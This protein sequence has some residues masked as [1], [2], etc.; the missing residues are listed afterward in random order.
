MEV[1]PPG[2]LAPS[3]GYSLYWDS[4]SFQFVYC[5]LYTLRTLTQEL[6]EETILA[7]VNPDNVKERKK[8]RKLSLELE[9]LKGKISAISDAE[10]F[11][12]SNREVRLLR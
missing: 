1:G 3:S 10:T 6:V 9:S 8:Q 7:N 2:F 4:E 5:S 12:P 11:C